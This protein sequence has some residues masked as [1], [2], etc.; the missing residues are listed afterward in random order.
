MSF[1]FFIIHKMA[2]ESAKK[3]DLMLFFPIDHIYHKIISTMNSIYFYELFSSLPDI[4]HV[5]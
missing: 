3:K 2:F 5:V 1:Q 4:K